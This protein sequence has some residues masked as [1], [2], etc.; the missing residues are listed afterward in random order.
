MTALQTT[1]FLAAA[2]SLI[3]ATIPAVAQDSSS[4]PARPAYYDASGALVT[5]TANYGGA[6][7]AYPANVPFFESSCRLETWVTADHYT[8][9]VTMCGPR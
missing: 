8:E 5:G 9:Y 7:G 4:A 3:A 1:L 2:S 6:N